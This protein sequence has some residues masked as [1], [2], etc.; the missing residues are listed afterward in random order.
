M[1]K[2]L[3]I[4]EYILLIIAIVLCIYISIKEYDILYAVIAILFI[5]ILVLLLIHNTN[6]NKV[7]KL[8]QTHIKYVDDMHK[9]DLEEPWPVRED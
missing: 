6:R 8:E 2:V 7:E 1:I 3:N 5:I 4:L 9:L